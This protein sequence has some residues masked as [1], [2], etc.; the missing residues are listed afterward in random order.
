MRLDELREQVHR[1]LTGL[2][3]K[4]SG[5]AAV[6][7][8]YRLKPILDPTKKDA[9][10]NPARVGTVSDIDEAQAKIVAEIFDGLTTRCICISR[11]RE[12]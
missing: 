12:A 8:G 6:F 11:L 5:L 10:G 9:Y 7:Y 2:A 3:M 1:G 4:I